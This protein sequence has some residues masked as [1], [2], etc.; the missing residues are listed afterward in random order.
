MDHLLS[1]A[2]EHATPPRPQASRALPA[3]GHG[4][5][6]RSIAD[7]RGF[8]LVEILI[9]V[10]I[11]G[12]LAAMVVP[13]FSSAADAARESVLRDDLRYLRTQIV[14]YRAQH[15][16]VNPGY[17]EG[18]TSASP[19]AS[20]F[21]QQMTLYTDDKGV[22]SASPDSRFKYGPYLMK[23]PE[24]P[25]KGSDAIR[26]IADGQ[27]MPEAPTGNEGW[28]YQPS[29]GTILANVEGSDGKGQPFFEY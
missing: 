25:V 16:G 23:M 17:P 22:T 21:L 12:I 4:R 18:D 1:G 20:A 24:N 19:T 14:V 6:G 13:K 8:T 27:D 10:A 29:T 28:V 15:N 11:L 3:I 5:G 26:I 9:V 7:R 2:E